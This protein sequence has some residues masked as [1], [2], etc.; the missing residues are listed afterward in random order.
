MSHSD[1]KYFRIVNVTPNE[2]EILLYEEIGEDF[3]GNGTGAKEFAQDLKKISDV[4]DLTIRINSPGGSV[5]EGLAIY[6]QLKSHRAYKTVFIDGLAAS[7]ASVIAMAGDQIIMPENALM[8]IHDPG[9]L[10]IGDAKD[11]R[12]MA[13]T[14]EKVKDGII[15]AYMRK[16]KLSS[17]EIAALMTDETWMTAQ[18]AVNKGFADQ[19]AEPVRMA[20][21]FDLSVF[22]NVPHELKN[23]GG[24][25]KMKNVPDK[26]DD[27]NDVNDL[28]YRRDLYNERERVQDLLA[29]GKEFKTMDLA[30]EFINEGKSPEDLRKEILAQIKTQKPGEGPNFRH[31]GGISP[32]HGGRPFKNFGEQL[33]AIKTASVP[34]GRPDNRLFEISNAAGMNEGVPSEGGFAIQEDFTT[35]LLQKANEAATLA[36][37]CQTIP[38]SGDGLKAPIIDEASRITGSRLG[39]VQAYWTAEGG[40]VTAPKKPKLAMLQLGL[41]KLMGVCYMT[42]ELLSDASA[43]ESV[44]TRGF[45]DELAFMLDA[46]IVNGSGAGQPLGILK[47]GALLSID[48]EV[49]QL[50]DTIQSENVINMYARMHKAGKRRAVWLVNAEAWPQLFQ[51]NMIFGTTAIPLYMPPGGLSQSPFGTL[52]GRP[53]IEVEQC[54]ALGDLG[55]IIFADFGEYL[56][57]DKGGL[58]FQSS[59]HVRFLTDEMCYRFTYRVDGQPIWKS[60]LTPYKGTKTVSP[61]IALEAR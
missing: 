21:H 9:G 25:T 30:T 15:T 28:H 61:F 53:V 31:I 59:M 58:N 45:T 18:E 16:T 41:R 27:K 49:G 26:K 48:K 8:M 19:V 46:A 11:M 55:D 56:L 38:V 51:L 3:F 54:E 35:V 40:E 33:M 52:F 60:P 12:K 10:V 39:G 32:M 22:R 29:I 7:I 23:F 42:D 5:F 13:D 1:K 20:A 34:G 57:I 6:N 50:A 44:V 24:Y 37:L 43:L 2:A 36:P 14:L 4:K 17:A 47:S